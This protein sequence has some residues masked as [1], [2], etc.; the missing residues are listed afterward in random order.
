[1]LEDCIS[2]NV[3]LSKFFQVQ[4]AMLLAVAFNSLYCNGF[5]GLQKVFKPCAFNN[6]SFSNFSKVDIFLKFK[7]VL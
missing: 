4:R 6:S 2:E 7:T 3:W 1:P 5:S